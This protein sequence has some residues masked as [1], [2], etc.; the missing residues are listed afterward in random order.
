MYSFEYYGNNTNNAGS[1][2]L[3]GLPIVSKINPNETSDKIVAHGDELAYLFDL[4]DVFGNSIDSTMVNNRLCSILNL[5]DYTL[6]FF[7][8]L[9]KI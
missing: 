1:K 3:S 7:F 8:F 2:F 5:N 9:V 4:R 6:N